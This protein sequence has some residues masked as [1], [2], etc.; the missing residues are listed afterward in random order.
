MIKAIMPNWENFQLSLHQSL[1][2][3]KEG[4][5]RGSSIQPTSLDPLSGRLGE[6][7]PEEAAG[8]TQQ[9]CN[10]HHARWQDQ[11]KKDK[12]LKECVT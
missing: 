5:Y 11:E 2:D 10:N 9:L 4:L 8:P 1:G 6:Q 12:E 3:I 7:D